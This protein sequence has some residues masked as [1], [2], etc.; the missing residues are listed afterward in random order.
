MVITVLKSKISYATIT[1]TDL[2]Y[3]GSI[4]IDADIMNRGFLI[5][6]KMNWFTLLI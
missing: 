3:V 4:T 6:V 2:Y 1:H 5:S